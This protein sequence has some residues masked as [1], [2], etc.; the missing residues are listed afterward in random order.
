MLTNRSPS[1]FRGWVRTT[2]DAPWL[3][4][5]AAYE[6]PDGTV[7][8]VGPSLGGGIGYVVDALVDLPAG[9][10]LGL[11]ALPAADFDFL[12]PAVP[13]DWFG[14]QPE[15]GDVMN[16]AG[17]EL[18][19]AA[20]ESAFTIQRGL[21]AVTLDLRWYPN[22]PWVVGELTIRNTHDTLSATWEAPALKFGDG[23]CV[24]AAPISKGTV[25]APGGSVSARV[26]FWWQRHL[27]TVD[28]GQSLVA[29]ANRL[30]AATGLPSMAPVMPWY[31]VI[32][33]VDEI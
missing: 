30:I 4:P 11:E 16:P 12:P 14:G 5:G 27:R 28:D 20:F 26:T 17:L 32:G 10:T 19:G 3:R 23:A 29:A 1:P 25:V 8:V 31:P 9:G 33:E 24:P 22:E 21:F 6:L 7:L 15:V 18:V 13:V 2:S